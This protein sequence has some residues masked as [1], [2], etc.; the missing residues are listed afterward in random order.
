MAGN[1]NSNSWRS[2]SKGSAYR[3]LAEINVTPM[4][5]VMLVLLIVFMVSA[6]L[7]TVGVPVNL[8]KADAEG[9]GHSQDPINVTVSMDGSLFIDEQEIELSEVATRINQLT[10]SDFTQKI[11][12]RGDKDVAYGEVV[13]A[14]SEITGAG[15]SKIALI[16]EPLANQ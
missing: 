9:I 16:S 10:N 7:L 1:L 13:K 11:F 6:P 8:P 4:V 15:Y 14:M 3:P 12:V 2:R 5:D